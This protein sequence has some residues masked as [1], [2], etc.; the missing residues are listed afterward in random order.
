MERVRVILLKRCAGADEKL[1]AD[2]M[3]TNSE[4]AMTANEDSP[5]V[6]LKPV[7]IIDHCECVSYSTLESLSSLSRL[8]SIHADPPAMGNSVS[9]DMAVPQIRRAYLVAGSG[10]VYK[11]PH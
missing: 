10:V 3:E 1:R 2:V 5:R 11:I 4:V 6:T 7:L 9:P 8:S